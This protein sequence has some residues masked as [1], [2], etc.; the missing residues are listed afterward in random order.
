MAEDEDFTEYNAYEHAMRVAEDAIDEVY[1]SEQLKHGALYTELWFNAVARSPSL[2]HIDGAAIS[3]LCVAALTDLEAFEAAKRLAS[4]RLMKGLPIPQ[5]LALLVGDILTGNV[6]A[7]EKRGPRFERRV[8]RNFL[9]YRMA[10]RLEEQTD[11][12]ITQN[13]EPAE[14]T[15]RLLS[16]SEIIHKTLCNLRPD[17]SAAIPSQRVIEKIIQQEKEEGRFRAIDD[18]R[19]VSIFD[20]DDHHPSPEWDLTETLTTIVAAKT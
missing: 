6:K 18:R 13:S 7:P 15:S 12:K 4:A 2:V 20:L 14:N 11:L 17:Q 16:M 3:K 8:L 19:I 9:I 5:E 10:L 1:F